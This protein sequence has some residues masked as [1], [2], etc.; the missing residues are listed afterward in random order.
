MAKQRV[1]TLLTDFGWAGPYVSEMKG[2]LLSMVPGL[3]LVDIS[4]SIAPGDVLAGAFVL[5]QV[6][7]TFPPETVH[8][9][10]VDPSV[11]TDRRVL[12]A[13]YEAQ[14]II[15]PDNG[16]ITLVNE[17][18]SLEAV[19][20]LRDER[21]F[22]GTGLSSTFQGRDVVAPVAA[23]L[24]TGFPLERLGPRP[25]TFRL[26]EMPE[27][28]TEGD[29]SIVGEVLY[30]DDFG[31]LIS[32]ISARTVGEVLGTPIGLEVLCGGKSVGRVEPAYGFVEPGASLAL[33]NSMNV[34]EV[35]VNKG[36]AC[37]RL[38]AGVGAEIRV[39]RPA[40]PPDV[41]APGRD[42]G[43]DGG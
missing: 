12:A 24:V 36:R 3:T 9:V 14:S 23:R 37:D 25:E 19:V 43:R 33:V 7:P 28:R 4:H 31:N 11:G 32:N 10:V 16:V 15:F 2:V 26:L 39:R 22:I 21:F 13:R 1:V 18:L 27:A 29:G 38:G 40:G 34:I 41:A 17:S 20:A 5:R 35:A 42:G 30:V 8:C 6:V